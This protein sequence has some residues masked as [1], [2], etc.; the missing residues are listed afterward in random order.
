MIEEKYIDTEQED[1][2]ENE[3]GR[4]FTLIEI[5]L[6]VSIITVL[7]AMAIPQ[8]N[9]VKR[10]AYE[11]GALKALNALGAAELAYRNVYRHFTNF[12]GLRQRGFVHRNYRKF[13][14][15]DNERLAKH[16]SI[17]FHVRDTFKNFTYGFAFVAFP[18]RGNDLNLHTFRIV[19]DGTVEQSR[20]GIYWTPR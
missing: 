7:V 5:L 15:T 8:I 16:Y 9:G 18:D 10:G 13:G 19:E 14:P 4:G 17:D 3:D 11:T 20:D 12:E 6:V 1:V 2:L